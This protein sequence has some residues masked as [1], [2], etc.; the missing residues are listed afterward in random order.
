MLLN[1]DWFKE[2]C[3]ITFFQLSPAHFKPVRR[4]ERKRETQKSVMWNNQNCCNFGRKCSARV[5]SH[6]SQKEADW[7]NTFSG[8]FKLHRFPNS[9]GPLQA[10]VWK[11]IV[12]AD[13]NDSFLSLYRPADQDEPSV[14]PLL[15]AGFS[16]VRPTT[17][18]SLWL[19]V[20]SR[21][22][23]LSLFL[24]DVFFIGPSH[25]PETLK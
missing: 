12:A 13:G 14:L 15:C 8:P 1:P 22:N 9:C 3:D 2:V 10:C 4:A 17:C 24:I 7:E 6:H 5:D 20:Y 16:R 11:M 19:C 23:V 21:L 25:R 18:L